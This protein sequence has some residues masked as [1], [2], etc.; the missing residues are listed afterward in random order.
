[1]RGPCHPHINFLTKKCPTVSVPNIR[2]IAFYMCSEIIWTRIFT[3][4][5]CYNFLTIHS[6]FP[7]FSNYIRQ[8]DLFSS[9]SLKR[10]LDLWCFK[11]SRFFI[12]DHLKEDHN[13]REL[14][15]QIIDVI[16]DLPKNPLKQE[17]HPHNCSRIKNNSI[18]AGPSEIIVAYICGPLAKIEKQTVIKTGPTYKFL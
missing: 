11:V 18:N 17:K 9:D 10:S 15:R 3:I 16:L 6:D 7:Y 12:V 2:Y 4:F 13:G 1:M 14:K 8:I 5:I